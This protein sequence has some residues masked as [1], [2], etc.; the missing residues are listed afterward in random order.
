M[1]AAK[2]K[3]I[4]TST[5]L[6]DTKRQ[7]L[8]KTDEKNAE[9]KEMKEDTEA[10]LAADQAFLA[11]LKERCASMD[12]EFAAR[13]KGRQLEI[14]AVS[15]ALA[16][17]NSDE[18]H[19]LFTRTFNPVLLQVATVDKRRQAV[20]N[21]LKTVA[22]KAKD[23]RVLRLAAKLRKA[24]DNPAFDKVKQEGDEM[25]DTLKKEQNDEIKKRDYCIGALNTNER[26]M[27]MKERDMGMK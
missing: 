22:L 12:E 7:E 5:D 20:A 10:A 25:I 23:K 16:F 14:A 2:E 24:G 11:D 1:K 19:D 26:D 27:G 18:A 15:K 6:V 21:M 4:E 3:E 9:D 17:L 8:A 13:T